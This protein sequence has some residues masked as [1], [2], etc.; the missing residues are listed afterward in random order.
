MQ[1]RHKSVCRDTGLH[2]HARNSACNWASRE[3][4]C[5]LSAF[6][7]S[8]LL[9]MRSTQRSQGRHSQASS[10][11]SQQQVWGVLIPRYIS[12]VFLWVSM[13]TC[14][15]GKGI[16]MKSVPQDTDILQAKENAY[17]DLFFFFKCCKLIKYYSDLNI[18]AKYPFFDR[19]CC[20]I[21]FP[22]VAN[23][24][25]R[26]IL[27]AADFTHVKGTS[28]AL[29]DGLHRNTPFVKRQKIKGTF[30]H[31]LTSFLTQG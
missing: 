2:F 10:R 3:W 12:K 15:Q 16:T 30:N 22:Q 21:L 26:K 17:T 19:K 6:P 9:H 18:T 20:I 4:C 13:I 23:S 29:A 27:T 28:P 1:G 14:H 7:V 25:E 31:A 24:Q 11:I 5:E 8:L